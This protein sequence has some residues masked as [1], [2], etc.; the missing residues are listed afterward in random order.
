M[1][2]LLIKIYC[3]DCDIEEREFVLQE[4]SHIQSLQ[5]FL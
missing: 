3:R 2:E 1:E 4:L 5:F